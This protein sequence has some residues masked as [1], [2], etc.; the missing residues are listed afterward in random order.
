M[1]DAILRAA[2]SSNFSAE[3]T[4]KFMWHRVVLYVSRLFENQSLTSLNRVITLIS[5][6]VPW[7]GALNNTIAVTRWATAATATPYTE[8]V[9]Q[10]VVDTLFQIASIDFLRPHIPVNVWALLQRRPS[11]PR[12]CHGVIK[13]GAAN[14]VVHIRRLGDIDILKSYFLLLW[15][16]TYAPTSGQARTMERS[17]R[18]DFGG[19]EMKHHRKDLIKRL[20]QVLGELDQRLKRSDDPPLKRSKRHYAKLKDVLLELDSDEHLPCASPKLT[21]FSRHANHC[22]PGQKPA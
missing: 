21:F 12:M 10:S 13:G 19:I 7:D 22:E 16:D 5:P 20:D 17:I 2:R 4:G 9:G 3:N 14:V 15:V 11:L 6:Y 1:A 8:E 18:E